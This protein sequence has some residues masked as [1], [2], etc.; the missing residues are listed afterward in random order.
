MDQDFI[1]FQGWVILSCMYIPHFLYPLI[2]PGKLAAVNNA[3]NIGPQAFES[4]LSIPLGMYPKVELLG[5]AVN[6]GWLVCFWERVSL[7][8][9][10]WPQTRISCLSLLSAGLQVCTTTLSMCLI[11]LGTAMPCSTVAMPFYSNAH[12][13][14]LLLTPSLSL[15]RATER[16]CNGFSL[17]LAFP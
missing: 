6:P 17:W 11:F 2:C 1:P 10:G 4:L 13:F 12:R 16:V 15:Y 5:H 8:S 14:Q 7:Y 3:V 9:R